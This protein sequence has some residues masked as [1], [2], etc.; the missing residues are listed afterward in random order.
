[1][2]TTALPLALVL[3]FARVFGKGGFFSFSHSLEGGA[4]VA[5][6]ARGI[7]THGYGPTEEAG[8]CRAGNHCFG[9]FHGLTFFV[10]G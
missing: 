3:A 8:D 7:G 4:R 6:R 2:L 1:M 5:G 10:C 9:W